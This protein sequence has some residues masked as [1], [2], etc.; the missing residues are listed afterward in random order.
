MHL[1]VS[2]GL[3]YASKDRLSWES[4][5][6]RLSALRRPTLKLPSVQP[7]KSR[8]SRSRFHWRNAPKQPTQNT[9]AKREIVKSCVSGTGASLLK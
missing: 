8:G 3:R 9:A 7:S 2:S 6:L 5:F 4:F 1:A